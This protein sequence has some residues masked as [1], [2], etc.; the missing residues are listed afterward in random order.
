MKQLVKSFLLVVTSFAIQAQER[1][2]DRKT[3]VDEIKSL[4]AD[5]K[6]FTYELKDSRT[7]K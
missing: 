3:T 6:D 7:Y 5:T 4:F 2:S 1:L